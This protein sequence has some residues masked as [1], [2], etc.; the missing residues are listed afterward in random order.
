M[1][2]TEEQQRLLA[3]A[4]AI[5]QQQE[6]EREQEAKSFF[7]TDPEYVGE[8][9]V[10]GIVGHGYVGKAVERAL[11]PKLERFLVD[12]NY[13]TTIDQ[14]IDARPVLSYVCTPTPVLPNGKIDAAVTLD[15]VLKL[16]RLTKSAVILKSTVTP[17]VLEKIVR[18]VEQC[19]GAARFIY[20]PEFLTESN[21][22]HEYCN[23][24]YLVFGGMQQSVSQYLE[25][26]NYNTYVKIDTDTKMH[27]VHP[28][29]ASLIKYAINCFL[30]MKVTF[31]NQFHQALEDE[32]TNGVVPLVVMRALADEPRL[33][34]SHWRVPGPDGK[35]GF[36][37]ACL[38]KDLSA[39]CHYSNRFSLLDKVQEI[40]NEIRQQYAIDDREKD[41]NISFEASKWED[42]ESES[43]TEEDV[44]DTDGQIDMFDEDAA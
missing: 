44:L 8:K 3:E 41:A 18:A 23:P 33:G 38:P 5:R 32:E 30:A 43:L 2:L 12:P 31:L 14:L 4:D 13:Q 27:V 16:M 28:V 11:H 21:A 39:F 20:A 1:S 15:A 25:F 10:F 7:P 19:E 17:D 34:S 29:E 40:N 36:G 42:K 26:V 37:G 24:K 35:L 22:D 6:Q 9:P